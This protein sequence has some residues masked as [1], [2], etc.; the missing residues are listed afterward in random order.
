[1]ARGLPEALLVSSLALASLA[2]PHSTQGLPGE[3]EQYSR[4][5]E[6]A[7]SGNTSEL[8]KEARDFQKKYPSSPRLGDV[9]FLAAEHESNAGAAASGYR[10]AAKLLDGPKAALAR[11]RLCRILYLTS[12]WD[13]LYAESR[14][15][16]RLHGA[17][18]RAMEFRLY[19][20]R[21][22]IFT[23]KYERA[24]RLC[25]EITRTSHDYGDLSSALLLL[26]H[27]ERKTTG[28]SRSYYATLRDLITGFP[29]A[30][31][32]PTALYLLGRS[33]QDRGEYGRAHSAYTEITRKYPRSHES[34][35]AAE[36]LASL[37]GHTFTTADHMPSDAMLKSMDA[38]DLGGDRDLQEKNEDSSGPVFSI[39]LGPVDTSKDARR[40]ANLVKD[41]FGPVRIVNLGGRYAVYAGRL[42]DTRSAMTMKI[43]LAEEL[44]LNG[45]IVRIV[46]DESKTY[47][48][49]D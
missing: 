6:L 17:D 46:R 33:Y 8:R 43:R 48:Y 5:R 28:Y 26:S 27:I 20:A 18:P 19:M 39:S 22:C 41:E 1:M 42:R 7:G 23:E 15:A 36:K 47:I 4:I 44:G 49:G 25:E 32:I 45:R 40:V 30:D 13:E 9:R 2:M 16:L 29:G 37:A 10:A 31:I 21:A 11:S 34:V 12:R 24:A 3:G 14:A 35:Y 38:I